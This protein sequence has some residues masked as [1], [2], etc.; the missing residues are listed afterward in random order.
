MSILVRA[1]PRSEQISKMKDVFCTSRYLYILYDVQVGMQHGVTVAS[2]WVSFSMT[3]QRDKNV[4]V[5]NNIMDVVLPT[6]VVLSSK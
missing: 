2:K 4:Q 1:Q 6:V 3:T 5:S